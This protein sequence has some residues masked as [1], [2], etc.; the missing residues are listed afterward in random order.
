MSVAAATELWWSRSARFCGAKALLFQF[1]PLQG[2]IFIAT[3]VYI[4]I[5]QLI[6]S[7]VSGNISVLVSPHG[8]VPCEPPSRT[9][10]R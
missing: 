5:L 6:S 8:G 9:V 3:Q 2:L 4:W 7:L 10:I 1:C